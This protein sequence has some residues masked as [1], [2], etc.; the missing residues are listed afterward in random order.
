M[1]G[2]RIMNSR[3]IKLM[4]IMLLF[5][6]NGSMQAVLVGSGRFE[7]LIK[8]AK[9]IVKGRVIQIDK[10][11]FEMIVFKIKVV[12]V[13]K[14]DGAEIPDILRLE[15]PSPI[16]PKDLNIPYTKNQ[17]VL[18]VLE[19][20][21][22]KI[23]V[24]NNLGAILPAIDN[25]IYH[26]NRSPAIRKVFD[27]LH[28]FLPQADNK[29]AKGLVLVYISQLASKT[30]EKT[31]ITYVKS[32]DEWL[33]R[34]ALASLLRVNATSE[35]IQSAVTDF[36]NHISEPSGLTEY[37]YSKDYLFWKM[38]QD[39]QWAARC[40][41]FGMEKDLTSRA[42]AYLAIYRVLIDKAPNDYQR[43]H[44]AIE[45]LKNVG[46]R[47]DVHRLYKYVDHE[48][49]WIRHDVLEGLGRILGIKIKRPLITSYEMSLP[50][51]VELWEKETISKIEQVLLNEGLLNN[52]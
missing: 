43:V 11:P 6:A 20:I 31:F 9:I 23:A 48:K 15:A 16:W 2:E 13:L 28:A 47:E 45:A 34:A 40:G 42:R 36:G 22:G 24:V 32:K 19:R 8:N 4:V 29:L 52:S 30:D 25:K 18:L 21:N 35:R 14:S 27:E 44:I 10:S 26:E 38:Y 39:V 46:T 12:N 17:A 5:F 37:S 7:Q 3:R 1:K 50:P 33:W 51:E 49:A 41:S